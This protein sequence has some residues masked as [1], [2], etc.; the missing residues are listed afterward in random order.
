[1]VVDI[2]ECLAESLQDQ[3]SVLLPEYLVSCSAGR[4]DDLLSDCFDLCNDD[5]TLCLKDCLEDSGHIVVQVRQR[6]VDGAVRCHVDGLHRQLR[7]VLVLYLVSDFCNHRINLCLGQEAISSD[8]ADCQ[9]IV[10]SV[11]HSQV[12]QLIHRRS[13]AFFATM[14]D[15]DESRSALLLFKE[16]VALD[17]LEICVDYFGPDSS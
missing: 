12:S 1:M 3:H 14:K 8:E 10:L 11:Q 9:V 17:F 5:S 4:E 6:L 15:D 16:E 7:W 13:F 2:G